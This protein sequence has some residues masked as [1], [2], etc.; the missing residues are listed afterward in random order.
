MTC[1]FCQ[2]SRVIETTDSDG[3]ENILYCLDCQEAVK[4]Q[5]AE[6]LIPIF[7]WPIG[8]EEPL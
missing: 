4:V 1:F 7:S 6:E 5:A 8:Q 3:V 2:G